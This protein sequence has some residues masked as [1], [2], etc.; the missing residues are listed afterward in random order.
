M[1]HGVRDLERKLLFFDIDGTIITG[2]HMIPKSARAALQAARDR[3]HILMINTGRPFRHIDPAVLALPMSG[4]VCAIGGYIRLDGKI[5]R[6]M[7]LP[8]ELCTQIR[9]TG[10]ACGMDMLFESEEGVWYDRRCENPFGRRELE[11]L[12]SIGVPS[13]E[14]TDQ[15]GFDFDKFVCWPR[16]K[17][18]P[19]RF[20]REFEDRLTFIGRENGMMEVVQKGLSKA[21]GMN[22]VMEKLD[23]P[24]EDTYA[25]GD[26]ANDLPMLRAA[27]TG[28]LLGNAP[29]ELWMEAVYISAPINEDGLSLALKHFDLI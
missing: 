10:Y 28:V 23:I 6:H 26:G 11:S 25:F 24:P 8:P 18:D 13:W 4:Y 5:L 15:D 20:V 22:L 16:E 27:G 14:D 19:R 7:T 12:R 3:G 9:D 29:R 17:A 21:E 2:D 1:T